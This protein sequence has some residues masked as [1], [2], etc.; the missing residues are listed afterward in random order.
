MTQKVPEKLGYFN[1]PPKNP[2]MVR[3]EEGKNMMTHDYVVAV[4]EFNGQYRTPKA[5]TQLFLHY[6]GRFTFNSSYL[7]NIKQTDLPYFLYALRL[8]NYLKPGGLYR[9]QV[10]LA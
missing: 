6:K 3:D 5:N 1:R 4:C 8:R 10:D 7:S 2:E 9:Y